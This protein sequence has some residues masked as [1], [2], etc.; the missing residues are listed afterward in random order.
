M[1]ATHAISVRADGAKDSKDFSIFAPNVS[2]DKM[3]SIIKEFVTKNLKSKFQEKV[4]FEEAET[5]RQTHRI[6]IIGKGEI[7]I[8]SKS[9]SASFPSYSSQEIAVELH[10]HLCSGF[11]HFAEKEIGGQD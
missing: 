9:F 3:H 2:L 8:E 4:D 5:N 10:K 7:A 6:V 1:F 11:C